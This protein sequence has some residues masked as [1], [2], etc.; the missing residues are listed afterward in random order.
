MKSMVKI[1]AK[2]NVHTTACDMCAYGLT[3]KDGEGEALVEKRT[4]LMSNSPEIIKRV[5][6]QCT[7]RG[8]KDV[9]KHHRHGDI[10]CGRA[11]QCQVY[12]KAF[13][14]AV[15]SG[16][17]AQKRLDEL[18]LKAMPIMSIEEMLNTVPED[19]KAGDP[20][21]DLHEDDPFDDPSHKMEAFDDVS[22]AELDPILVRL[23]RQEEMEYFRER[24][25]YEKVDAEECWNVTG[26]GPISV[27][28][29][30]IN[31]GDAANPKYRSRLVAKEFNTGVDPELFA[32]TPP[33]RVPENDGQQTRREQ[34]HANDVRGC[35]A[36]L[37]LCKSNPP[38]VRKA[39]RGGHQRRRREARGK[40]DDE[41]VR[42]KGCRPKLGNRVRGHPKRERIPARQGECMFVL[43]PQD[44]GVHHGAR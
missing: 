44:K 10:T 43:Q 2:D 12:P 30:D 5:S 24:K 32:A 20:A 3:T 1:M 13:C 42:D 17:A 40:A 15:C 19:L 38:S 23:A 8:E 41:H 33:Q 16:I 39:S 35:I 7:N 34:K 21:A 25:V 11:R 36:R 27:R 31:K 26:K 37:L 4:R 28:W 22:G 9:S 14:R 29:I 6:K 18:G